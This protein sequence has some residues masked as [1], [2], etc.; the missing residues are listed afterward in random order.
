MDS[1]GT[2]LDATPVLCRRVLVVEGDA[3]CGRCMAQIIDTAGAAATVVETAQAALEKLEHS[4]GWSAVI[5]D[6]CLPD[7]SGLD[8][9]SRLRALDRRAHALVVSGL[10][11]TDILSAAF[12]LRAAYL[13]KPLEAGLLQDFLYRVC[14]AGVDCLPAPPVGEGLSDSVVRVLAHLPEDLRQLVTD[15]L[16]ATETLGIAHAER[17]YR[18]ALLA[19]AVSGRTHFGRSVIDSCAKAA[20]VSRSMLQEYI[21][22]TTRWKPRELRSLL[23]LHDRRGRSLTLA[24]LLTVVRAPAAL[25]PEL[26]R[27]IRETTDLRLL[28]ELVVDHE[29]RSRLSESCA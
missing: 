25:R 9:L 17:A 22:V 26:E 20:Q 8:V 23:R 18:V 10:L 5:V 11:D 1:I 27:V 6:V 14:G 16:K 19:R 2:S 12:R 3:M 15:V 28:Q 29:K 24:H 4:A 21:A 7:G 13:P